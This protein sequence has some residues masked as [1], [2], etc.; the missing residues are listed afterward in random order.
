L[1]PTAPRIGASRSFAIR[2]ALSGARPAVVAETVLIASYFDPDV[3]LDCFF[4]L[5]GGR[6]RH[7]GRR[8]DVRTRPAGAVR[9]GRL[10]D[11]FFLRPIG[12]KPLI[13]RARREIAAIS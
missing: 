5:A 6:P 13:L 4:F 7:R 2:E 10:V 9:S 12:F 3:R 8:T 11:N 1:P